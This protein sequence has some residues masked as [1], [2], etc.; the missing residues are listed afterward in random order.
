MEYS[1]HPYFRVNHLYETVATWPDGYFL[2]CDRLL[3]GCF[4]EMY[5]LSVFEV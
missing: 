3:A 2:P 1:G 5:D 4:V